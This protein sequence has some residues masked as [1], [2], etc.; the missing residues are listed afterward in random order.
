M[1]AVSEY[2]GM[3]GMAGLLWVRDGGLFVAVDVFDDVL[4]SGD[5]GDDEL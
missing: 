3:M 5:D 4:D 2:S 1:T